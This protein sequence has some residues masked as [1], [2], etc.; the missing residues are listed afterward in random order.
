M[1]RFAGFNFRYLSSGNPI[2]YSIFS[3]CYILSR[4]CIQ[5]NKSG[6]HLCGPVCSLNGYVIKCTILLETTQSIMQWQIFS[7]YF[8]FSIWY[9]A[10]CCCIHGSSLVDGVRV[11]ILT[12]FYITKKRTLYSSVHRCLGIKMH[13]GRGIFTGARYVNRKTKNKKVVLGNISR[14]GNVKYGA[15]RGS[16]GTRA[17]TFFPRA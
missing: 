16:W 11:I 9:A 7:G 5:P 17:P 4:Y 8:L 6:T 3:F 14:V 13:R 12:K 10:A 15:N 2:S 1:V